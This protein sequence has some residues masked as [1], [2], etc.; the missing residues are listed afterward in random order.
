MWKLRSVA[1]EQKCLFTGFVQ[2]WGLT[3]SLVLVE[4]FSAME[5]YSLLV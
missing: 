2:C 3:Q 1:Y 5:L 4:K